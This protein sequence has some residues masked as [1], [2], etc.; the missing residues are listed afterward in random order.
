MKIVRKLI[1]IAAI[2]WAAVMAVL[3]F[4]SVPVIID[5]GYILMGT[6]LNARQGKTMAQELGF[7]LAPGETVDISYYDYEFFR[8]PEDDEDYMEMEVEV[9]GIV[10]TEEFLTRFA[11]EAA[12]EPSGEPDDNCYYLYGGRDCTLN[13]YDWSERK[14]FCSATFRIGRTTGKAAL[15]VAEEMLSRNNLWNG[16]LFYLRDH[17]Y[18]VLIGWLIELGLI[19]TLIILRRKA[20]KEKRMEGGAA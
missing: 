17:R 7:D 13:V 3:S 16:Y 18:L 5:G 10:S 1:C 20:K 4:F 14:G 8:E 9:T 19:I 12:L 6:H 11:P 2:V 15:A